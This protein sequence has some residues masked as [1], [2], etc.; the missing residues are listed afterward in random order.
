[1]L[2]QG[3]G[4]VTACGSSRIIKAHNIGL[5]T[6]WHTQAFSDRFLLYG[7]HLDKQDT[8]L[9]RLQ[10]VK[11]TKGDVDPG[12]YGNWCKLKNVS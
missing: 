5:L 12:L 3:T 2:D 6:Q 7:P 10:K 8:R 4:L 11:L 9:D 1:M